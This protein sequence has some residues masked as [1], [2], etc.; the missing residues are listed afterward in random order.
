MEITAGAA[1]FYPFLLLLDR[2]GWLS[3]FLP[4]VLSH[5][6]GH[7]IMIGLCGGRLTSVRVEAA[8][9]CIETTAFTAPA[10]ELLCTAAGP[11]AGLVWYAFT[12]QF[13]SAWWTN[14]SYAALILNVF[15]LLP[16]LPLDGGR[17]LSLLL[18]D[19]AATIVSQI[20]AAM[21]VYI[22]F[23]YRA[24]LLIVPAV[25]ICKSCLSS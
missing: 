5:E 9:L 11:A 1:L 13:S 14:A 12:R 18:S 4:A 16:A 21:L 3:V 22:I 19:H 17:I 15:N 6:L 8:G 24:W 20:M 25:L 10:Q 7:L 2:E 23:R